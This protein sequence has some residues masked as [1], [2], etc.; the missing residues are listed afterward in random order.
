MSR[1][2]ESENINPS[3]DAELMT[4]EK[5]RQKILVYIKDAE[6]K[7]ARFQAFCDYTDLQNASEFILKPPQPEGSPFIPNRLFSANMIAETIRQRTNGGIKDYKRELA[8]AIDITSDYWEAIR[9]RFLARPMT[10]IVLANELLKIK[11]QE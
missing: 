6:L 1:G 8:Q 4:E 2:F 3:E 11:E 7:S 10:R 5:A 9:G